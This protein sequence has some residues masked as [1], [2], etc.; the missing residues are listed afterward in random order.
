M[1]GIVELLYGTIPYREAMVRR[2]QDHGFTPVDLTPIEPVTAE[3]VD[4]CTG[5]VTARVVHVGSEESWQELE[6]QSQLAPSVAVIPDLRIEGFVRALRVGAGVVH[7]DNRTEVLIDVIRAVIAGEVRLPV[8]VAQ[9]LA[10]HEPPQT[11]DI[12]AMPL[13]PVEQALAEMISEGQT[14][15][16]M[17][18]KLVYS[19]RTVRRKLQ[20][21]Y[22]KLGVEGREGARLAL[23]SG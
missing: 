23:S 10:L 16:F 5:P 2:L 3:S 22:L 17:A 4:M 7:G 15:S 20:G 21:L 11:S 12:T 19:E 9:A 8:S 18:S 1:S 6:S 13:D 14:T